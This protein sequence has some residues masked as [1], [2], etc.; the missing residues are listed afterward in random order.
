MDT[1]GG[2]KI[3]GSNRNIF[4]MSS[5]LVWAGTTTH[6]LQS[7]PPQVAW[8]LYFYI[9]VIRP[10]TIKI[11][12]ARGALSDLVRLSEHMFCHIL[13]LNWKERRWTRGDTLRVVDQFFEN[14]L[15]LKLDHN[16][17]C[18]IL[19]HTVTEHILPE[20]PTLSKWYQETY[21]IMANHTD[22]TSEL[23]YAIDDLS[24]H[25]IKQ[26][27]T[28]CSLA[29]SRAFHGWCGLVPKNLG[30]RPTSTPSSSLSDTCVQLASQCASLA[31]VEEY[32]L[33]CADVAYMQGQLERVSGY[34]KNTWFTL[35]ERERAFPSSEDQVLMKVLALCSLKQKMKIITWMTHCAA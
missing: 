13:P 15:G 32:Q 7:Y 14:P 30:P 20:M 29:I 23:H 35:G 9:G 18:Q 27:E 21:N 34:W 33:N 26:Q 31:I 3:H 28:T 12:Q 17:L 5:S 16:D 2:C 6:G 25:T 24:N 10:F 4:H 8:P 11:L 22:I 19:H 1:V